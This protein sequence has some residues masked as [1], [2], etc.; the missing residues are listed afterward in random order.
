MTMCKWKRIVVG[1]VAAFLLVTLQVG[2]ADDAKN[3]P[4]W[5]QSKDV[6][7]QALK[8]DFKTP[9]MIY[10]PFIFWFWDEPLAP[11]KM[12]E[13]SR[14][15]SS[16]RLQSRLRPRVAIPWSVRP[17]LPDEQW[18]GERWFEPFR[19]ALQEAE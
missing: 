4:N 12:A 16:A 18:L 14:V 2:V 9:N 10:A 11:A 3:P 13:M 17:D 1:F 5:G 7:F 6:T 15:M 8:K 19:A